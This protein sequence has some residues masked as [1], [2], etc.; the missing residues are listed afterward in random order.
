MMTQSE[1]RRND[2][3]QLKALRKEGRL[4]VVTY[5]KELLR[6]LADL[7]QN[8]RDEE[9][10]EEEAKKQIP[11]MLVFLEEQIGKLADRGG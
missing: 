5:Y 7:V 4:D 1:D 3:A 11:L 10:A 2:L 6:V 8:L 9:I